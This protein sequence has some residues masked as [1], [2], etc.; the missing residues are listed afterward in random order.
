[1][2]DRRRCRRCNRFVTLFPLIIRLQMACLVV[3]AVASEAVEH[4]EVLDL[5]GASH[6]HIAAARAVGLGRDHPESQ[7]L[8]LWDMGRSVVRE[9]AAQFLART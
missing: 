6:S 8:L 5:R 3:S 2:S 7:E 9:I 1:M 4:L